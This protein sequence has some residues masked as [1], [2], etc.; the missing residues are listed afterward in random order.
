MDLLQEVVVTQGR[1]A[2]DRIALLERLG[3][4]VILSGKLVNLTSSKHSLLIECFCTTEGILTFHS[5]PSLNPLPV[6]SFPSMKG[7]TTFSLDEEEL[8]GGG[9]KNSMHICAIK[10]R[11]MHVL[12]VTNEGVTTIKVSY[13]LSKKSKKKN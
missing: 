13:S 7:V 10:R 3:K 1:K 2:A 12:L 8:A 9:S 11:T 4:A 6:H 5:L